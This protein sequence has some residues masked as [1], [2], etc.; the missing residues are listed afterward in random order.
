MFFSQASTL[1]KVCQWE[2]V[3]LITAQMQLVR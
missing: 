2:Q 3:F 1:R